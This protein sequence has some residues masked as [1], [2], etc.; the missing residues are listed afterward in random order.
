MELVH[1]ELNGSRYAFPAGG[2]SKVLEPLAVTP[3]PYAPPAVEGLVNV[4]GVV[5]VKMDLACLLD[6]PARPPQAGG[7]LLIVNGRHESVVVQ[8][9]KVMN[10]LSVADDEIQLHEADG[11]SLVRG[12]FLLDGALALLLDESLLG[13]QDVE[14]HG[15]PDGGG[16]LLGH[17]APVEDESASRRAQELPVL[18]VRD[19]SETYAFHMNDVQ[20]IVEIAAMTE[21]PGAA[22]AVE[23]LMQLRGAALLVLSLARLLGQRSNDAAAH[24]IVVTVGGLRFGISVNEIIGMESHPNDKLQALAV[25]DSQLEGYLPGLGARHGRMTGLLSLGGLLP[26]ALMESCSRYLAHQD[27]VVLALEQE[28]ERVRRLLSFRVGGERCALELALVDRV[29]EYVPG[30]PLPDA[31]PSFPGVLQIQG[32][33]VAEVDLGRL[34]GLGGD[35]YGQAGTHDAARACIVTHVGDASWALVADRVDG[36]IDIPEDD[37]TPIRTKQSDYLPEVGQLNGEL[38]SLLTLAPLAGKTT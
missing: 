11:H 37:I 38:I 13:L 16:G 8:V 12:E 5:M 21:L 7:T 19:G 1:F 2:I 27:S 23:G 14:P 29:E 24:V 20:E 30:V 6:M 4:G 36:V 32:Q 28:P 22:D 9:D 26:P 31:D 10:K 18:A 35:A 33:V 34:L 25:G 3:L 17:L 15:V